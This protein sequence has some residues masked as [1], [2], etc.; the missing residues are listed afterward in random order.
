MPHVQEKIGINHIL[1][2]ARRCI[3]KKFGL[4]YIQV[5]LLLL[6][7]GPH[8]LCLE[9]LHQSYNPDASHVWALA[10][11]KAQIQMLRNYRQTAPH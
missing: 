8:D 2:T 9:S 11:T 3:G 5:I 10:L 4:K 6:Q 7:T 1:L